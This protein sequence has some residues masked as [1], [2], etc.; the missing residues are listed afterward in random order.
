MKQLELHNRLRE[1]LAKVAYEV[2][3]AVA[4]QHLDIAQISENLVLGLLKAVLGLRH[5][6][7]L[8]AEERTN[9][10]GVDLIDET[11][12]VGVQVTA[13]T[14]ID[15]VKSTL[16]TCEKHGVSRRMDRLIIYVLT[17][18]QD[19][20]SQAAVDRVGA[21]I[22]FRTKD[23][24]LDFRDLAASAATITPSQLSSAVEILE[25][26]ARG[27]PMGLADSDFDPTW[28][29]AED[30]SLTLLELF[31]P[32]TVYVADLVEVDSSSERRRGQR[33]AVRKLAG[34]L[35]VR[36]PSDY[37]VSEGRLIT[38]HPMEAPGHLFEKLI[39][40]GTVT[41]LA[42]REY[43]EIDVDHER[44]FKGLLR[45]SMQQK[46]FKH[47][48]RWFNE[49]GLFAFMP[50]DNPDLRQE[51]WEGKVRATRSVFVRKMN[52]KHEDRVLVSKHLAFSVDFLAALE[53]WF[54]AL[55]PNWYFSYGD[56]FKRSLYADKSLAWLKRRETNR[57]V[58][59]HFRFLSVW[60][61]ELDK[62]DLFS[63][64]FKGAPTVSFGDP[65]VLPQH[66]RLNDESWLPV[67]GSALDADRD[68]VASLFED[69]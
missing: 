21:S 67:R 6:R 41:P 15:K 7:N 25:A 47:S 1:Q 59:D 32:P 35:G 38:F 37:M 29:Q 36:L 49:E 10:P 60:L 56:D 24:I 39:D 13:S 18:R 57:I 51:P 5:L 69:I 50:T 66:P 61:R 54:V 46:L 34:S 30:V 8:N 26:F 16:L 14:T 55:A 23:D 28:G 2:E 62:E 58:F 3:A 68:E 42:P 11:A 43:W 12:R 63:N 44:V 27:V 33:Q 9:F 22:R 17:K 45:F 64:S 48:V 4:A 31:I 52:K 65:V 20:Y 19:S 40:P 53:G